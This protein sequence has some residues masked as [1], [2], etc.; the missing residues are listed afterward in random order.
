MGYYIMNKILM[1]GAL[2]CGVSFSAFGMNYK[3]IVWTGGTGAMVGVIAPALIN[4]SLPKRLIKENPEAYASMIV[5]GGL[6]G[7]G[8][9]WLSS[10]T[11]K[12]IMKRESFSSQRIM[13][14]PITKS[15]DPTCE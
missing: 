13:Q 9:G 11:V 1:L 10:K 8:Y 15:F 3:K 12:P 6:L 4:P 14:E 7:V 5:F 2:F